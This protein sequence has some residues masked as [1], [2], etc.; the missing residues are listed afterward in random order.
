MT[1]V[2]YNYVGRFDDVVRE[3]EN[4]L[5]DSDFRDLVELESGAYSTRVLLDV[6]YEDISD[7]AFDA[8]GNHLAENGI[9]DVSYVLDGSTVYAKWEVADEGDGVFRVTLSEQYEVEVA[10]EVLSRALITETS[11]TVMK[12]LSNMFYDEWL[13]HVSGVSVA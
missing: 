13:K 5:E 6:A 7:Q 11:D 8:L 1:T 12:R 3:L 9:E 4:V 10:S 2:R